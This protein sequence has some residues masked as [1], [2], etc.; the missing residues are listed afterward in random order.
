MHSFL[1]LP[2]RPPPPPPPPSR[3]AVHFLVPTGASGSGSLTVT[4]GWTGAGSSVTVP[5]TLAPGPFN[6]SVALTAVDN[7]VS[8]WW[9]AQTPGAQTLYPVTA[10]FTPAQA[11][12]GRGMGDGGADALPRPSCVRRVARRLP[13]LTRAA[14]ASACSR[15]SRVRLQWRMGGERRDAGLGCTARLSLP[16]HQATTLTRVPSRAATAPTPSRCASRCVRASPPGRGVRRLLLLLVGREWEGRSGLLDPLPPPPQVNGANIWSRGA[17][18]I[19][20]EELEGRSSDAAHRR[21]VLS[22]VEG[23][24]NTFR[25]WGG[26]IFQ[27]DAWYDACDE[28]GMLIYH[29]AMFAQARGGE[30]VGHCGE[31]PHSRRAPPPPSSSPAASA[32]APTGQPRAGRDAH[33]DR[34]DPPPGTVRRW[35]PP[36]SSTLGTLTPLPPPG[37]PPEPPPLRRHLGRLQRGAREREARGAS[38]VSTH[39]CSTPLPLPLSLSRAVQRRECSSPAWPRDTRRARHMPPRPPAPPA[40]ARHLRVLRHV[41]DRR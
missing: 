11:R 32:P 6:V 34:R 39:I 22:A 23:G 17:N 4:G 19:P 31:P 7:A 8:L 16:P 33:A 5:V 36:P 13:S 25:L 18:M 15:S 29:D 30:E 28:A 35:G 27:Y 1:H 12:G 24:F 9:P 3:S 21:L 2:P 26:G 40:A 37:P 38:V 10:T 20:M 14:S 41:Y